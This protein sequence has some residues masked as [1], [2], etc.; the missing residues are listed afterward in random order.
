MRVMAGELTLSDFGALRMRGGYERI[1][2]VAERDDEDA[3]LLGRCQEYDCG[4]VAVLP[5]PAPVMSLI[6]WSAALSAA[7]A[8]K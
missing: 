8:G 5:L 4:G 3:V 7:A 1:E 6:T 2:H